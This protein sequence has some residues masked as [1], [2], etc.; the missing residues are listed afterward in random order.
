MMPFFFTMPISRM[1][2]IRAMTLKLGAEED[3]GQ[4]RPH[5]GRRQGGEDGDRVDVALVED[6]EDDVDRDQGRQD[7]QRLVGQ[8]GLE[9][10]GRAL[11]AAPDAGGQPQLL[12][13]ASTACTA[14]PREAPGARLKE[15]VTAGN[16]P[17]RL[18]SQRSRWS[19]RPG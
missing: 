11:E 15:M 1:M 16:C 8:G 4:D 2:P 10:L 14:S 6:A 17:W 3:E 7:Q 12:A 18:M 9:G 13:V 5:P 19:P